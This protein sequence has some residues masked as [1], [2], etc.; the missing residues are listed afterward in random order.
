[1]CAQC[2]HANNLN[3]FSHV[4]ITLRLDLIDVYKRVKF[5]VSSLAFNFF[6]SIFC[7]H[8]FTVSEQIAGRH[9]RITS[10]QQMIRLTDCG[11][12]A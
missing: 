9:H 12:I 2:T 4:L 1:M 10:A 8:K 7:L 11:S 5:S 3:N 6:L